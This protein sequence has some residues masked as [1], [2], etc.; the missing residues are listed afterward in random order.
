[1]AQSCK[2]LLVVGSGRMG[3]LRMKAARIIPNLQLYGVV[4]DKMDNAKQFGQ[5]YQIPYA[6]N[7]ESIIK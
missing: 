2:K 7:I 4:D 1:M 6:S 5:Q 3:Q